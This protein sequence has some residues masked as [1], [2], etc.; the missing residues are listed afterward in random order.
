M[1]GTEKPYIG[2]RLLDGSP[3]D[4]TALLAIKAEGPWQI[5]L[6]PFSPSYMMQHMNDVPGALSGTG[7]QVLLT[8]GQCSIIMA[9]YI[10]DKHFVVFAHG[11]STGGLVFNEQGAYA[12]E[13]PLPE[14]TVM[15]EIKS[16]GD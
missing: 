16:E 12:G 10:R 5:Q 11:T 7:N 13:A 4:Q 9:N 2:T 15:L 14:R 6:L 8:R 1:I 3:A